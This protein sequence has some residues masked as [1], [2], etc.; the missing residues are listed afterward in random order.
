[1]RL[2]HLL[3]ASGLAFGLATAAHAAGT[4]CIPVTGDIAV[5]FTNQ[6]CSSPVGLCTKGAITH[7]GLLDG[8]TTFS[9]AAIA[10]TVL[11]INASLS[12]TGTITLTTK[13]GTLSI[14]DFG[15][16]DTTPGVASFSEFSRSLAGTG[17][18][19]GVAGRLF[20]FGNTTATGFTGVVQGTI[21]LPQR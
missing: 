6:N 5:D 12:Y 9:T 20:I 2:K 17:S 19:T 7:S 10:G 3:V 21:C 4:T 8:S 15:Q 18:F 1:M 13:S 16:L 11:G 14:V